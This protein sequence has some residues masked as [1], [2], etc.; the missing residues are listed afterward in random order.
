MTRLVCLAITLACSPLAAFAQADTSAPPRSAE[1]LAAHYRRAHA[2]RDVD[3]IK[4]LFYWGASTARSRELVSSFIA[5]DVSHET[6]SITIIPL[7]ASDVTQYTQ[8]GIAYRM[9]LTPTSKLRIDF[10]PRAANG[11]HYSSEQTI[12]FVGV[13]DGVYWLIT[14]EPTPP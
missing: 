3:A 1:A 4:R 14:A 7:E 10:V 5:Q 9:T 13:R 12:Y 2:A 6:R 8:D 11:G